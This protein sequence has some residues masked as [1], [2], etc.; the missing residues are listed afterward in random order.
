MNAMMS[1]R[2]PIVSI[3]AVVSSWLVALPCFA[4]DKA[5]ISFAKI[6]PADFILP[7]TP[8]IDSNAS[9]VV[10]SDRGEVHYV[11]NA[12]AWFSYVY[13]RQTRIKIL[14]KEAIDLATVKVHLYGREERMERLTGVVANTYN[15]E[16]GQIVLTKLDPKDIFEDRL[17]KERTEVKFSLPAVK[18][19]SIIEY[20]Y[21]VTSEYSD[22]L[23]S[24]EFQWEKFPCL[25]SEYQVE[26]PQTLSFVLVRQGIHAYAVDKG[27]TGHASYSVQEQ[28][29]ESMGLV[30]MENRGL[31]VSAGTI[32][33]DWVMKDIPAF[34]SE[35]FLTTPDNYLDKIDFQL[36][37]TYNG[38]ETTNH[39]NT[40]AKA[41]EELMKRD[42]FG[43]GLGLESPDVATLADKIN[44][45]GADRLAMARAVYYY[46]S[47]HFTCTDHYDKYIKTN[48][49]DVIRKNSGTVGDINLL[50]IALLMK[51]GFRADPVLLSTRD[52]GFSLA[53]YPMLR[54]MNYVIT[55]LVVD[56]KVYYL[57]AAHPELGFGQLAGEC[58]N[59]PARIISKEDS[60]SVYFEA[61]SLKER[62]T[63]LVMLSS[64][65]RGLEGSWQST[66][67]TQQSYQARKEVREHGQQQFFKDIQTRYG[68][69][70]E[71][72][73]GGIDSLGMPEQPVK[74]HY[75]FT[76]KQQ[77]DAS[78]IYLSPLI[79]D[80]WRKNPFEA[81]ERKYPVEL[82]YTMDQTFIFQ[83]DIPQGYAVD[84]L[85]KST[86]VMLNGD[87]G[88][89]EYLISP[90]GSQIQ[91][92][93]RLR[94]NKAW[95]PAADYGDLRDFF[96]YIVKKEAEPIVLK[97]K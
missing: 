22:F 88:Q 57:D 41:T 31:T 18:T 83:M 74:V 55:R 47:Q 52:Y 36:S 51:K 78:V 8:I 75:D 32:K 96:A 58:Y 72:S 67:G 48:F 43:A 50:L 76:L 38:Q 97:K 34:G 89:F 77:M 66:L 54:R 24:W 65:E 81:A 63:T 13:T 95:Y 60:G 21:T 62:S 37:A 30:P 6:T 70:I 80:G 90:Q 42:D 44:A 61:D 46:V 14:D 53:S 12:K 91:M 73:N 26:I 49:A 33:H 40:W 28:P 69:D 79:G 5:K 87:Q 94:L 2:I 7:N 10:L 19:G 15:V 86:R 59:G 71:I 84:E 9:A 17:D 27:S 35:P 64:T 23:P 56:G 68:D 39:A 3:A 29:G 20:Q 92:R 4:Q 11:G 45:D 25:F 85:P 93:C 16:N 1:I 82:P